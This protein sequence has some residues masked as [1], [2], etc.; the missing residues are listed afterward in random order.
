MPADVKIKWNYLFPTRYNVINVYLHCKQLVIVMEQ[1]LADSGPGVAARTVAERR[2][3]AEPYV[4]DRRIVSG[5]AYRRYLADWWSEV[6]AMSIR[7]ARTN[8]FPVSS[9][10][11][12]IMVDIHTSCQFPDIV[13]KD[14]IECI[15]MGPSIDRVSIEVCAVIKI[16]WLS[17][18]LW[19]PWCL[20]LI[21]V[22]KGSR[23][24]FY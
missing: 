13:S 23:W 17:R 16:D 19:P 3:L 24:Q 12:T 2:P 21:T 5:A 20:D 18:P 7:L 10:L 9:N 15:Y 8:R 6:F 11:I 4:P 1:S 14:I 22:T